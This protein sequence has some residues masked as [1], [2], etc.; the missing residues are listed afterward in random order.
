MTLRQAHYDDGG[1]VVRM[2]F[3]EESGYCTLWS[4]NSSIANAMSTQWG[5]KPSVEISKVLA[6]E[7]QADLANVRA[8]KA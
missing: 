2:L 4:G 8:G 6:D 5:T 3:S 7:M 1:S